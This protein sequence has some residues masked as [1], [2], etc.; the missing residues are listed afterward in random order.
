M[1]EVNNTGNDPGAKR[2]YIRQPGRM[3]LRVP[4]NLIPKPTTPF[5]STLL[6]GY[7]FAGLIILG[8]LLLMLPFSSATGN[9]T[10]PLTAFFTATSAVCV[11]GLVVVDTGT[12]WST[13][14]QAVL[15]C[16]MQIGGLGFIVGATMMIFA[17]GGRFGLRDRLLISEAMGI[18]Q[19]SGVLGLVTKVAIFAVCAEAIG[20]VVFYFRWAAT[21]AE[22][23]SWWTAIFHSAS[24]F[25]NCG[26]DLFGNF[27]SLLQFRSDPITLLVT[28]ALIAAGS[29]GYFVTAD[30]IKNR[31]FHKL[32]LDSKIVIT[33]TGGLIILA[34]LFFFLTEYNGAS[35][36]GNLSWPDKISVAFF[37]SV[38][39]RTAGFS[40]LNVGEMSLS[41][42]FFSVFLMFIGGTSGS[43]SGG[44]KVNTFGTLMITAINIIRGRELISAFG[45]QITT[46]TVFRALAL[47]IFYLITALLIT[48]ILTFIENFPLEKL[49]FE[50]FSAM[51]TVGW[52]TGITPDLS[53]VGKILITITMYIGRL[54][55]LSFMAYMVHR[56]QRV[57]LEY[58]RETIKLG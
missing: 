12:F 25:N 54:A 44:I 28:A 53:S 36:L 43:V 35:T 5:S 17:I 13:F 10:S 31:S 26:M 8:A 22:G 47:A 57:E 3:A 7:G 42:I 52:S 4:L 45:R 33:A 39:G 1:T 2:F 37:Q 11:T 51:G 27:Q 55:P 24:A 21:G 58:P 20:V 9:F 23:A 15:F 30:I 46:Q 18:N 40:A 34:T 29:T 48:L 50:T 19:L 6:L 14:G 16:L 49:M 56:F 41:A 38:S 32:S